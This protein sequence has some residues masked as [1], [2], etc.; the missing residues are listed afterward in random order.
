MLTMVP[1]FPELPL[2]LVNTKQPRRT[3]EQVANVHSLLSAHPEIT[4]SLL[5]AIDRITLDAHRIISNPEFS[6]QPGSLDLVRLGELIRINHG[7][8]VSL[9]VSHPKLERIRELIDYTG[10]GW[11]KLTGA[12]GG[13]CS[14]TLL[15][16]NVRQSVLDDLDTKLSNE[17][18][19]KYK[20]TLG[21]DG[22]GVLWP[23]VLRTDKEVEITQDMFLAA[24]G[25]EGVEDL[26]GV[27]AIGKGNQGWRFWREWIPEETEFTLH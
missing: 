10:I 7:L 25:M 9:G 3:S 22:V 19:E 1:S 17:G 15:K 20:T 21:G 4:N 24:D 23:A 27:G 8:L 11:T 16:Q 5:D 13:G 26:V 6:A 2:L 18:F 12:G 14:I